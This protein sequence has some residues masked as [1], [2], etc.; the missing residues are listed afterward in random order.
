MPFHF[1]P[2]H[3]LHYVLKR[4]ASQF[5]TSMAIR[6][7]ALGMVLI[8]EPIYL[9]LYFGKSISF[10]LLFF[11][12]IHGTYG[13]LAVFGG[14]IMARI[15][16]KHNML[17]SNF[18]FFSYFLC[19]FFLYQSFLFAPLAII[20]KAIGMALFWPAFHT[21][22]CRFS[23]KSY[24][25]A[26]VGKMNVV[27]LAPTIVSPI[28]GGWI[29]ATSGY[30]ALFATVS[31]VLFASA[32]PLFLSKEVHTVYTDSYLSSWSRIFKKANRRL[33]LAIASC[34][35][36]WGVNIVLWPIF[37]SILAIGYGT[38]GGITTF[39]I[40][41]SG[42]FALY[43]GKLSDRLMSRIKFL[44]IGSVLTSISWV[45][46][47]FVASPFAAF[48]AHTLYRV[49][50]ITATIPFETFIYKRASMKGA[51]MDEFLVYRSMLFNLTQALFFFLLAIFFFFV[52]KINLS[53]IIAAI[54]SLGFM[55][56][57]VPPKMVKKLKWTSFFFNK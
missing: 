14:K 35:M 26:A 6:Y 39:A 3:F 21:D 41:I 56:I 23:E 48:L 47:I 50:R 9:Y 57:G 53:F 15:G 5:F 38:M 54:I 4:E 30:P 49:C 52:S 33:S 20:L 28:I 43:I 27:C 8:F 36:E 45:I 44:N 22:F 12:A 29:L 40:A 31:V 17:S 2:I 42:L 16:P 51:E 13:V 25:G 24:Q 46:K 19:L 1:S 55:F 32:I 37:M 18:F 10:T 34:G 7:L 11:A